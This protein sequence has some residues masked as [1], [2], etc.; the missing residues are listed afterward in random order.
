MCHE[1]N[2]PLIHQKFLK[3]VGYKKVQNVQKSSTCLGTKLLFTGQ[4]KLIAV[5]LLWEVVGLE[6]ERLT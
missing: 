2:F 6:P 3:M 1:Q 5:R 4:N